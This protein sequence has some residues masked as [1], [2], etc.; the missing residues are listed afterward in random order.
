MYQILQRVAVGGDTLRSDQVAGIILTTCATLIASILVPGCYSIRIQKISRL[1]IERRWD[2]R[3]PARVQALLDRDDLRALSGNTGGSCCY[4]ARLV[5]A[6]EPVQSQIME[7][8]GCTFLHSKHESSL[9]RFTSLS[10]LT[11]WCVW[12]VSMQANLRPYWL[13]GWP[14]GWWPSSQCICSSQSPGTSLIDDPA[15][16]RRYVWS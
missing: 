3:V 16:Q 8:R 9:Q 10:P 15:C 5:P 11:T 6:G 12:I 14:Q 2:H 4:T 13:R 1:A 7:I